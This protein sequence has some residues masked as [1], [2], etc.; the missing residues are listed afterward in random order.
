VTSPRRFDGRREEHLLFS[1][2]P[3]VPAAFSVSPGEEFLVEIHDSST[4]QLGPSSSA[5]S[6]AGLRM[7]RVDAVAGPIEIRG[8][9]AGDALEIE[10]LEIV[11]A[12][13]GWSGVFRDFGF[14]RQRFDDDLVL[15]AIEGGIARPTRGFL[16]EI[17]IPLRPMIGVLGT[18]PVSGRHPL[19]PPQRFGGNT[20]HRGH[21]AGAIVQLPVFQPGGMLGIGDA[22]AAQGDGEVCGT[23]IEMPATVRLRIG[24]RSG[25]APSFP[26]VVTAR[27]TPEPP[28][29]VW[30]ALGIS[31]TLEDAARCALENL[32]AWMVGGGWTEKEAY[33][34]ASLLGNLRLAEV[35]DLPNYVVA[36]DFPARF[37]T[38][39]TRPPSG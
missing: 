2:E 37:G 23:G 21:R 39:P 22:H 5:A 33:L 24:V 30:S 1:W 11:P 7:D 4:G 14:L 6:L 17:A 18:A 3:G 29:E 36:I 34:L 12:T 32:L 31:D 19:I 15:W 25:G 35:V 20:D 8:A 13:W 16:R 27:P 38:P 9:Q 10:I 26:R 28:G